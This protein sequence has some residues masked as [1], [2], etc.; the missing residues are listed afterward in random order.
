MLYKYRTLG[1][2]KFFID[3]ILNQQL[4]AA[5][6]KDL[7]DPMEGQYL[8]SYGSSQK[9]ID[10]IRRSKQEIRIVSL[11]RKNNIPLMW[12]HYA[13]GARGVAIG[14]NVVDT[15]YKLKRINYREKLLNLD[16]YSSKTP[17]KIAQT[18]LSQKHSI[19][20]YE[21]EERIFIDDGNQFV[22]VEVKEIITGSNMKDKEFEFLKS[23]VNRIDSSISIKK[24]SESISLDFNIFRD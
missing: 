3:I 14:V 7:N 8:Y 4:Y 21:E 5:Q 12:S 24:A 17:G 11:S 23:L 13:N 1:N 19:W 16:A 6:Y 15:S 9:V 20:K 22:K 10:D 2:Y 18:I